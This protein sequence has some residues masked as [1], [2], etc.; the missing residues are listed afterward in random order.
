MRGQLL[1][2]PLALM[3]ACALANPTPSSDVRDCADISGRFS[4]YGEWL[5]PF[6]AISNGEVMPSNMAA[7]LPRIDERAFRFVVRTITNLQSAVL[8]QDL[9]TGNARIDILGS[10]FDARFVTM[11]AKLPITR[12][13]K[14]VDGSWVTENTVE[15]R[16]GGFTPT[17]T[18]TRIALTLAKDGHLIAKGD[19]QITTGSFSRSTISQSWTAVFRKLPKQ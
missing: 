3:S 10:G 17:E 13:L 11:S 16:S 5:K 18:K 15:G 1:L 12:A 14:C 4:F 9:M 6:V 8:E 19:K 7:E 2:L